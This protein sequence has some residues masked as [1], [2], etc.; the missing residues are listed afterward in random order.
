[1]HCPTLGSFVRTSKCTKILILRTTIVSLKWNIPALLINNGQATSIPIQLCLSLESPDLSE[2]DS[3]WAAP[4]LKQGYLGSSRAEV[5]GYKYKTT[6][7]PL[8]T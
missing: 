3:S 1:M 5:E 8:N 4:R 6:V 7:K 2:D